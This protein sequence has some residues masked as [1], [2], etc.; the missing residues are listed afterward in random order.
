VK[1]VVTTATLVTEDGVPIE[2]VHLPGPRDLAVVMAHGFTQS[3]QRPMVW[4]IAR[5]FNLKAGVVTFDFRGHGRSGGMST[6]GDKEINDLDVAVHYAREIG[7]QRVATAGF[8][9][10]GSVVLRQAGLRHGVD[11]AVSISGPGRWFY[12]GTEPMRRVHF[13]AEKRVG[14]VFARRFLHTRIDPH[15]W[16][17]PDPLPP[18]DAAER[19]SPTPVLIVHGD[20]DPFFPADHARQLYAAARPPK[21]L[22][23][24]PGFGHAERATDDALVDRI[25][26]WIARA[27][28]LED[29]LAAG[30]SAE[31]SGQEQAAASLSRGS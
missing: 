22:W 5:R 13:V 8:S 28:T 6:L 3:W 19:I 25:A 14:R 2:A 17:T 9:M 23:L 27:V 7:Y 10:G 29:G 20:R 4:Q 24:I 30:P 15:G 31:Q 26:A 11:A 18:A 1:P 21:E 16:P 12:R